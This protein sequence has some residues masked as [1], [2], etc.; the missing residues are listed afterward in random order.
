MVQKVIEKREE[1]DWRRTGRRDS[2]TTKC[3]PV[4]SLPSAQFHSTGAF[5]TFGFLYLGGVQYALYVPIF[6]R[7]FPNA[8]GFAA[9]SVSEKLRDWPG[10]RTLFSQVTAPNASFSCSR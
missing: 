6:S 1:V 5:T 7:M 4:I 3:S 9:K 10:I 8:A 2:I